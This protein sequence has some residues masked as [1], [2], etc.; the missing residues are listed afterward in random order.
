MKLEPHQNSLAAIPQASYLLEASSDE[1]EMEVGHE[2]FPSSRVSGE[3]WSLAEDERADQLAEGTPWD[4][5]QAISGY[6]FV[7]ITHLADLYPLLWALSP[8]VM[9]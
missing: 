3:H 9:H 2:R 1:S 7:S 8:V 6:C 5:S 4:N